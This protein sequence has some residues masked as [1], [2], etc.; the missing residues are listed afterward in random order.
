MMHSESVKEIY[1][2]PAHEGV[3]LPDRF[4]EQ[5]AIML[6][7]EPGN[8]KNNRGVDTDD[9]GF[10]ATM[11]FGT[12][13]FVSVPWLAITRISI[14]GELNAS[15]TPTASTKPKAWKPRIVK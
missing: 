7:L 5:G 12:E 8:P 13:F 2:V 1:L 11:N 15:F 10:S 3:V 6:R 4:M 9:K 14:K